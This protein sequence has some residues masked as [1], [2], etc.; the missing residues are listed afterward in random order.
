LLSGFS[1]Q[2]YYIL[3]PLNVKAIKEKFPDISNTKVEAKDIK[4]DKLAITNKISKEYDNSKCS[5]VDCSND[6]FSDS[7]LLLCELLSNNKRL[8]DNN[9]LP[10]CELLSSKP[11]SDSQSL[12]DSDLF[13]NKLLLDN[14]YLSDAE[15]SSSEELNFGKYKLA[16]TSEDDSGYKDDKDNKDDKGKECAGCEECEEYKEYKEC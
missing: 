6:L 11:L 9:P 16:L 8:L 10:N 2:S 1:N 13:G 5:N 3:I 14:D 15:I 12:L 7:E 4:L